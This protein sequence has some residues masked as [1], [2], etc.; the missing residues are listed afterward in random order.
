MLYLVLSW[1]PNSVFCRQINV[2]LQL[3][4]GT[5]PT[6]PTCGASDGCVLGCRVGDKEGCIEGCVLGPFDCPNVGMLLGAPDG[7][8]DGGVLGCKVGDKEGCVEG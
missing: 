3:G 1:T 4:E 6:T 5:S 8:L 2:P 7:V